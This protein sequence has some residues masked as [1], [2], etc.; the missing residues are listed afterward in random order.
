MKKTIL[1]LLIASTLSSFSFA[2]SN[3]LTTTQVIDAID[4][5]N[6]AVDPKDYGMTAMEYQYG[7]A[8]R[9]FAGMQK[10]AGAINTW[11][12]FKGLSKFGDNW[13]VS[14]N[15]DTIYSIAIVDA[16]KGFTIEVPDVGER[17]RKFTHARF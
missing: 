1:T 12:H 11:F 6:W 17:F 10:R 9:L 4:S 14:P 5:S 16:R 8:N 15:N 2:A 13:V 3:V 7:E